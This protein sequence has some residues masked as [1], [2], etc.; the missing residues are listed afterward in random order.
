M[1][2]VAHY[3]ITHQLN[4]GILEFMDPQLNDGYLSIHTN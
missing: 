3:S 4:G 1:T 2:D